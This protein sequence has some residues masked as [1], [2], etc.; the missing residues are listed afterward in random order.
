M[1]RHLIISFIFAFTCISLFSQNQQPSRGAEY[2]SHKKMTGHNLSNS[3]Q[4]SP[5]SPKHSF[6]VLNYTLNLDIFN[7]FSSPF[8]TSFTASNNITFK[9]DSVLNQIQLNAV[10]TS[11][12]I[13]SVSLPCTSY[14]HN[15][16]I[17]TILLDQTYNPGDEVSLTI[18]YKHNNVEDAA[19]YAS[20]G[21][22]FTDC[23]PEG[24]RKWFPCWDKPSDKATLDL[25]AKVPLNVKLGSN[26]RLQ[27]STIVDNALYYHWISIHPVAT[28]LTVITAKAN[29]NL[30]IVYWHKIS[31]PDDSVPIRFYYNNG[32]NPGP[33]ED[34]IGPMTTYYSER[35]GEH[36][37]EKN[38]F[39]TLN[40]EFYWGGMENQ[41]LT[42]LCPG[43]WDEY[44]VAHEF[45]HQ[46]FGDMITCGTWA[47][48]FLNEGFA[49][50]TEAHWYEGQ[51]GYPSYHSEIVNNANYYLNNNPGWAISEPDWAVNTPSLNVL[52][53]YAITY[54]KGSCV[55]HQL[56]YVLG[57]SLFFAGMNA[58]ATDATNF[59]YQS[60]VI[61][62]FR[63]KM[64]EVSGQDLNWFFDEWVYS[65]N[66]PEYQNT[67]SFAEIGNGMWKV[68]FNVHQTQ[69]NTG[70]FQMPI[71]VK[72]NFGAGQD[73]LIR[74]MNDVNN[75]QF[76]WDFDQ[77]PSAIFFDPNNDIVLKESTL[78][79]AIE[80]HPV[81]KNPDLNCHV[82]PNPFNGS[83]TI[84]YE[85][86]AAAPVKIQLYNHLGQ[87]L[88]MLV[89]EPKSEGLQSKQ[90]NAEGLSAGIYYIRVNA[91]DQLMTKKI[92]KLK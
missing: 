15:N 86:N 44:Y 79:T 10:N 37:F 48:I 23:E 89:D 51:N 28:Y 73:T 50:W 77:E 14:T 59:M 64:E 60:S 55:L 25:T 4:L 75:Q 62:D 85:L 67:Y 63:D 20:G 81:N 18:Y 16:N 57:D 31:N 80:M 40:N 69:T 49:T 91:G 35:F 27:D 52:F 1:K 38:G 32:E 46:W 68:Y 8:P 6:D 34:I 5:N 78:V 17:L 53:N 70:F 12:V 22:V 76:E 30:D 7:C 3:I 36:P 58:Y 33:M 41:T 66:H 87:A 84:T 11:L 24:A 90:W 39:A 2:C 9:V 65:P 47:D 21:F 42:S 74:V 82:E 45:A 19:F 61:G 71:E 13:D 83:I 56:R 29:Y 54:L 92:I 72:I 88:E 26:G 43:C